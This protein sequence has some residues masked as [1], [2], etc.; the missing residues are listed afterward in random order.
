[1]TCA[2]SPARDLLATACKATS[3]EHAVVRLYDTTTWKQVG[4]PLEGHN[5]TI[6]RITFS[7]D[8]R[9]I[10]TCSRDRTWRL[11]ESLG[12]GKGG[13]QGRSAP[14]KL[15]TD[16]TLQGFDAVAA[17]KPH[18]RIIWDCA[19]AP[20]DRYFATVSRDKQVR[21]RRAATGCFARG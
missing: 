18:A 21:I 20:D 12:D 4:S 1:M 11:F 16:P 7:H 9:F 13:C 6:T 14:A 8:G 3:A 17:E 10:L 19:W 5:L 15:L 2:V